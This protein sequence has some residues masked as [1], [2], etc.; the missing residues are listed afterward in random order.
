[1]K[2]KMVVCPACGKEIAA[3]A[4]NCPGC[5]AKIKKPF[6][7][8][9]WFIVL[10]LI[11]LLGAAGSSMD[12]NSPTSE[13]GEQEEIEYIVCTVDEMEDL[14][15]ENPLSAEDTYDG[16]YI[17]MTGKL[18]VIDSD[19]TYIGVYALYNNFDILGVH[20][21]IK[22]ED[23]IDEIK[24]M[25]IGDTITVR[26]KVTAVGEILGYSMNIDEIL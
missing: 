26:G 10:V 18:S 12:S 13:D 15:N 23:Q 7:K 6:Y 8:K 16:Q 19:G 22:S 14:L 2:V 1:M 24:K 11:I 3:N 5:G 9:W 20:C 17:E 25:S 21:S 4:K